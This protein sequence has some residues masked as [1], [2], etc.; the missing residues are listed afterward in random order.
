M[1]GSVEVLEEAGV[2][3]PA[4]GD[5][6]RPWMVPVA[7]FVVGAFAGAVFFGPVVAPSPAEVTLPD[8]TPAAPLAPGE[9]DGAMG[10]ARAVPGFEHAVVAIVEGP[11]GVDYLL[12]PPARSPDTIGLPVTDART[13]TIDPS[14]LWLG[15]LTPLPDAD[16]SLLSSGRTTGIRPVSTGVDSYAWHD[17]ALGRMAILRH[18]GDSWAIYEVAAFPS[19][20]LAAELGPTDPGTLVGFGPWGWALQRATS[21]EVLNPDGRQEFVGQFLDSSPEGFL[22]V[23]R[24]SVQFASGGVTVELLTTDAIAARLSPDG[25]RAAVL[26]ADGVTIVGIDGGSEQ[27]FELSPEARQFEWAGDRFIVVPRSPR[28]I[29]IL[30][31]ET[32]EVSA[33]LTESRVS[34]AGVISLRS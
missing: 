4:P 1:A 24:G 5:G 23:D 20:E 7:A 21:F 17:S 11:S 30:D 13:V 26:D 8:D 32:G 22:V 14:G 19:P 12:W 9:E 28:G 31:T 10:A 16:G 33:H 3:R 18:D 27:R 15:L 6:R 25:K 2:D 29:W 34:W